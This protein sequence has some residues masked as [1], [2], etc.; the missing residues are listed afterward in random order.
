ML[1][2]GTRGDVNVVWF[3]TEECALRG[4]SFEQVHQGRHVWNAW[5]AALRDPATRDAAIQCTYK[6]LMLWCSPG[7]LHDDD[8]NV[9]MSTIRNINR[10]LREG[11][12]DYLLRLVTQVDVKPDRQF[13]DDWLNDCVQSKKEQ[14]HKV[15]SHRRKRRRS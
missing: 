3:T 6:V 4:Y 7:V 11:E 12:E 14:E 9:W 10:R 13:F 1:H 2:V 5:L 15:S 8:A